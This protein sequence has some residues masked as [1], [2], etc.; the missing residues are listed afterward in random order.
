[1]LVLLPFSTADVFARCNKGRTPENEDETEDETKDE[2]KDLPRMVEVH[3]RIRYFMRVLLVGLVVGTIVMVSGQAVSGA[4][5]GMAWADG[6]MEEEQQQQAPVFDAVTLSSQIYDQTI[7][8]LMVTVVLGLTLGAAV[9][10]H[11]LNGVGCASTFLF[12]GWVLLILVF[13]LPLLIYASVRSIFNE[14]E[15][16]KDCTVFADNSDYDVAEVSCQA[17]FWTFLVGG[18]FVVLSIAAMTAIGIKELLL[19]IQPIGR[20]AV[21]NSERLDAGRA[22]EKVDARTTE[23]KPRAAAFHDFDKYALGGFR[24]ADEGFFNYKTGVARSNTESN[25]LLYAPRIA[26][27]LPAA[28]GYVPVARCSADDAW[29]QQQQRRR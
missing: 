1:M 12:F 8:T 24:S 16:N 21:R 23:A 25:A 15:A 3:P 9:Q 29:T 5:F 26:F 17:R 27:S 13:F 2:T 14:N 18:A 19:N 4:G 6:I 10:R 22:L 11:L 7:A 28:A 20:V